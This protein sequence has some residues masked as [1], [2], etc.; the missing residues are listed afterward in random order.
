[1]TPGAIRRLLIVFAKVPEPGRTKTRLA[2]EI[3]PVGVRVHQ[4]IKAALDPTGLFN[5]GKLL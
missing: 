5:P 1:M 4:A 2:R 3:G